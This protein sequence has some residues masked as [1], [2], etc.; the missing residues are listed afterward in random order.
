MP[1][2]VKEWLPER[3]V[4]QVMRLLQHEGWSGRRAMDMLC[5]IIRI[6]SRDG[7]QALYHGFT[8]VKGYQGEP[9]FTQ[10]VSAL[11]SEEVQVR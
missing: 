3:I 5:G 11:Q 2:D 10:S 8:G 1:S 9:K 7:Q 6:R 4:T